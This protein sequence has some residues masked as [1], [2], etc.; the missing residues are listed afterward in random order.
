MLLLICLETRS[1]TG[2][3]IHLRF[4]QL[5]NK[6]GLLSSGVALIFQKVYIFASEEGF[7]H[8]RAVET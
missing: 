4:K 7:G 6:E 1:H 5:R 2:T 8:I 3:Y